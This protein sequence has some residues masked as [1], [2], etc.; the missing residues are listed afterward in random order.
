MKRSGAKKPAAKGMTAAGHVLALILA[1]GS[2]LGAVFLA[3]DLAGLLLLAPAL[4]AVAVIA[5]RSRQSPDWL[6]LAGLAFGTMVVPIFALLGIDALWARTP[7]G[8]LGLIESVALGSIVFA[9]AAWVFLQPWWVRKPTDLSVVIAVAAAAMFVFAV[10]FH[11]ALI[12][13]IMGDGE[14]LGEPISVVSRLDVIVLRAGS[15]ATEPPPKSDRGWTIQTWA[16]RVDGTRVIW[17]EGGAPPLVPREGADRVLLLMV[18]G[19]PRQLD[20]V[21]RQPD[22]PREAGEVRRWLALADGVTPATTP[23]YAILRTTDT[24]RENEWRTVLEARNGGVV[25]LKEDAVPEATADLALRLAVESPTTAQDLALAAKHRP[26]IFFDGRE[27]Y[28]RLVN[29]DQMMKSGKV[30][31]CSRTHSVPRLC[32][33]IESTADLHNDAA[34]LAFTTDELAQVK[35]D[36]TVYVHVTESG[37]VHDNTVYLDYWWYLPYNS[38]NVAGGALCGAGF[39]IG[40]ITCHDHQSDWEGITVALDKNQPEAAPTHV[41]YA[42]HDHVVRYTWRAL[43]EIWK[44]EQTNGGPFASRV[45]TSMRPLVFVARG[46]H[47]SYPRRCGGKCAVQHVPGGAKGLTKEESRDGKAAWPGN[48]DVDCKSICLTALPTRAGGR[49]RARWN[50]FRGLWGTTKCIVG[51]ACDESKPPRSPGFQDRYSTPWCF[52]FGYRFADGAFHQEPRSCP[53]RKEPAARLLTGRRLLALGDSF[54]SGQGAGSYDSGT[55]GGGNTCFRSPLAW[56]QRAAQQLD[57]AA[58]QSLACSGALMSDVTDGRARGQAE[59]KIS[60]ISR[61]SGDPALI[62]LTIS[63]NDADFADVLQACIVGDCRGYRVATGEPLE[64]HIARLG[65]RLPALYLA[66]RRAAPQARLVVA[67]YPRLFPKD[68]G[69]GAVDNC[70]ALRQ[71]RSEEADYL[72]QQVLLL[73]AAVAGA[74]KEAGVDFVDVTEAFDGRELRCTG[75]SY[76]NRLRVQVKTFPASF[77]PN[78]AGHRRLGEL[79]AAYLRRS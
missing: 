73:N 38:S 45:D 22:A 61:I 34:S 14:S 42:Q 77:H 4:V 8:R 71:I 33:V 41:A 35:T 31:L 17:G 48:E 37:N 18:D 50:A 21:A 1:I 67:G 69:T 12:D 47:A 76:L 5:F 43:Q 62:T 10:P 30:R 15:D 11:L 64:D 19:E 16:G 28:R 72:N 40:G 3:S 39:V 6:V 2:V 75:P 54:S 60:Q 52:S 27:P 9:S 74:T 66:V 78:E 44:D 32:P 51:D 56:P 55:S 23:T 79:V 57:M 49:E 13:R 46:R 58:L 53:P 59:R 65:R 25:S 70:A 7:F 26:Y 29:I 20:E 24:A 68:T 36:S 63:G